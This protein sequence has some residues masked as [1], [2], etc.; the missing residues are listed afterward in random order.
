MFCLDWLF[1]HE[2]RLIT[3]PG[4]SPENAFMTP[5]GRAAVSAAPIMD[6]SLIW[7]LFT[8]CIKASERLGI[9]GDFREQLEDARERLFPFQIGRHGQ[10]QEWWEDFE[11]G[12]PRHRHV[13]HLYGLHP[14][15][16]IT[17]RSDPAL[18][19]ACRKALDSAPTKGRAGAWPGR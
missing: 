12:E 2:G 5:A 14:G 3:A 13:S 15:R 9:D 17:W 8:N 1:E 19:A 4:T 18:W 11:E 7:D 10:L 6:M 16:Q